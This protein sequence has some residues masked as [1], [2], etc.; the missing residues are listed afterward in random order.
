MWI[1]R[2]IVLF[3]ATNMGI[4]RKYVSYY[5]HSSFF[6]SYKFWNMGIQGNKNSFFTCYFKVVLD[7]F[8]WN[9]EFVPDDSVSHYLYLPF[10]IVVFTDAAFGNLSNGGSHGGHVIFLVDKYNK[11][12]FISW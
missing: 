10:K 5:S 8:S 7:R 12:N 4:H 11:S 3:I 6:Y 2:H 1:K 9:L